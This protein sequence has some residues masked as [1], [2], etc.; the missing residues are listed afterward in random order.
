MCFETIFSFLFIEISSFNCY[1]MSLS[2][3]YNE[4]RYYKS[5]K[6]FRFV[7]L[8]TDHFMISG[9][10]GVFTLENAYSCFQSSGRGNCD[11]HWRGFLCSSGYHL[12]RG[13][14]R[15]ACFLSWIWLVPARSFT[16][17]GKCYLD[18]F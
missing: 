6:Y 3:G 5:K 2:T 16:S 4:L 17:Q 10:K 14:W 8:H 15:S 18:H 13:A 9:R 7:G 1:I 11:E 12:Q